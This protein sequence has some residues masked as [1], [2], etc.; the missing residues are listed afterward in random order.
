MSDA[1]N[2]MCL[3]SLHTYLTKYDL[4]GKMGLEFNRSMQRVGRIVQQAF[5]SLE[6]SLGI[7]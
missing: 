7:R 3:Q 5:R 4:N 6:F 1:T 2:A